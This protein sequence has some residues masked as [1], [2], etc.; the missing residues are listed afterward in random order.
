M[1][2]Y[3][4]IGLSIDDKVDLQ[5]IVHY[6]VDSRSLFKGPSNCGIIVTTGSLCLPRRVKVY[7][8][9]GY[10][11]ENEGSKLQVW[12]DYPSFWVVPSD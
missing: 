10:F 12:V 1:N 3:C 7:Q 6:Y 8:G 11:L 9:G 4:D 5:E 2:I